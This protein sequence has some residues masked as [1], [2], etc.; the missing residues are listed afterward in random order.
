MQYIFASW[1]Q[2]VFGCCIFLS[3]FATLSCWYI[4]QHH[5]RESKQFEIHAQI[6]S[7][8]LWALNRFGVKSYLQLVARENHFKQLV[9]NLEDG[10]PFFRFSSPPLSGAGQLAYT[11]HLIPV[12]KFSTDIFS[13]DKRI[14][15]LEGEHY[16][17][18]VYPL[19]NIFFLLLLLFLIVLFVFNLF[20]N[21]KFLEQLVNERTRK[22]RE[23]E[24]RF[25]D[26]VNL[27]PEMVA[28]TDTQ[29]NLTYANE[30]FLRQ[31]KISNHAL[32][33]INF[34]EY[35]IPE[36][37][38]Q[39]QRIFADLIQGRKHNLEE[40]MAQSRDGTI[41]P[42]LVSAVPIYTND[43]ISGVR[44]III[45]ITKRCSLEKQLRKA[46]KMEVI[47]MMAGGVAHDLN[48]ILSGVINYPELIMLKLPK[49]SE[50]RGHVKAIKNAGLRATAVVADLLTVSRGITA[51][52]TVIHPNTIVREYL[53]SPE[54]RQI[55]SLFP[56]LNW[57]TILNPTVSNISCSP[58][59]VKNCLMN[60]VNNAAEATRDNGQITITTESLQLK[61][62]GRHQP[63]PGTYAVIRVTDTAPGISP[64]DLEHIFEP[65][66]TKKN[67]GRSG[68]GLGL[69]VVWN[70][71]LEHKGTVRV[72]SNE[73]GT[74][75]L[76]YFPAST[77]EVIPTQPTPSVKKFMGNGE[78]ILVVDDNPQQRDIA[79]QLLI[80]LNYVVTAVSSG[81]EAVAYLRTRFV[82]ILLLDMLM[83]PGINGLQTY[84][85]IL[86]LH[87]KQ[88]AVIA[89]GFSANSDVKKTLRLG[90]AAFIKKPYTM[91]Q[92][93]QIMYDVLNT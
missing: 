29:G 57:Q 15:T 61:D 36:Q 14:G 53:D 37:R 81:E 17:H 83:P 49:D 24:R 35:M 80:S 10:T 58:I 62:K 47:G 67:L 91:K 46:Q 52:K 69:T 1:K 12:N 7:H 22:Y 70:T 2:F 88:K 20:H 65:F 45:D 79:L 48:N 13:H 40:F 8:D 72:N 42:V 64:Q 93:G 30:T 56:N 16:S 6:L 51:E 32:R 68:T 50:L 23:S 86:A 21:Q 90:T 44:S 9:V 5:V 78:K 39:A 76:L 54:F 59:H 43:V 74:T 63:S 19:I 66:Y 71:M 55:K 89:S 3:L 18:I 77:Q 28:E 85:Q 26:L 60:L 38:K 82:H 87:P 11:L 31:F 75:F 4:R 41:F 25:H 27:L 84:K 73:N 33:E 92:L 34:L